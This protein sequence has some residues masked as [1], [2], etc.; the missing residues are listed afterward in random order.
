MNRVARE[1]SA[2]QIGMNSSDLAGSLRLFSDVFGFQNAGGHFIWGD[3]MTI[4]GLDLSARGLLWVL[5]GAK[6][7]V[8]LELF[9]HTVPA[10]RRLPADWRA[11]DLGW[12]RF[13]IA[14][15][16]LSRIRKNLEAWGI[17]IT[18]ESAAPGDVAR[19]VFREPFVGCF[20]EVMEEGEE[21]PG[22]FPARQYDVDGAVIHATCS[23]SD[24]DASRTFYEQTLGLKVAD[25][26]VLHRPEHEALWGLPGAESD[27]FVVETEGMFLEIVCYRNPLARPPHD[28]F[29]VTD[30]GLV[31]VALASRDHQVV[32]E[33][34]QR[35]LESGCK[36][37]G[38]LSF[39]AVRCAYVV[40][41]ER[42][43][44]LVG[45]PDP[46][47]DALYGFEP[48]QPF[49]GATKK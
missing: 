44:E 49:A 15:P 24:L 9:H 7:L 43:V 41:S 32:A 16:D 12:T 38:L 17:G 20:I 19:L 2:V 10:Q 48:N 35:V 25:S 45:L 40:Q 27:S 13:G 39:G 46:Q 11:S 4:Q 8:Q 5:L 28:D 21:L 42:S 31:N 3:A 33:A 29:R 34:H 22:G 18:G 30:Q 23:V 37:T 47:E 36:A 26:L 1:L 6:P 14:V